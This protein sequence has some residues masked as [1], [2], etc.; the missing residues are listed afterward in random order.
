MTKTEINEAIAEYCGW[1][2]FYK[3]AEDKNWHSK[4]KW[5]TQPD[6]KPNFKHNVPNY[7]E[8]LNAMHE[9]TKG[10]DIHK[11]MKFSDELKNIIQD[12]LCIK[13]A[14]DARYLTVN[15]TA[16]QRAEAFLKT[17]GKWNE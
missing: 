11:T 7:C 8:D 13:S 9:A 4:H 2:M 12:T 3:P 17:I 10:F 15:S 1:K 6:G 5:G 16:A 14:V